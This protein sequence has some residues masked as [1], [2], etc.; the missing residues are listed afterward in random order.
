MQFGNGE[1]QKLLKH[2][3]EA[4][5]NELYIDLSFLQNSEEVSLIKL[6]IALILTYSDNKD[7]ILELLKFLVAQL[8][9]I[10]YENSKEYFD[11]IIAFVINEIN[12][13]MPLALYEEFEK[14]D[15][16]NDQADM[17]CYVKN[18]IIILPDGEVDITHICAKHFIANT[19]KAKRPCIQ[20]DRNFCE[21]LEE[22][23]K[24]LFEK[25][26]LSEEFERFE[27]YMN[28]FNQ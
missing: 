27:V 15:I 6:I 24:E 14:N 16:Q 25:N 11:Q 19:Y 10:Y 4:V 20:F 21:D 8:T 28:V 2:G 5:K 9:S 13:F 26:Q 22:V 12:S 18:G 23:F 17:Y 3:S 7:E 1:F